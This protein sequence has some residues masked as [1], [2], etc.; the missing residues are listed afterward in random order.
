LTHADTVVV[1]TNLIG[2]ASATGGSFGEWAMRVIANDEAATLFED[3]FVSIL[4]VWSLAEGLLD[5]AQGE[6]RGVVNL[7]SSQVFSKAELVEAIAAAMGRALT[8]ARRGS[9]QASA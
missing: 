3:Q 9:V 5:L 1:R 7:A 8:R 2:L 6:A 4:D